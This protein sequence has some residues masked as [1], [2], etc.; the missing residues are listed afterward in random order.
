LSWSSVS[1]SIC[2]MLKFTFQHLPGQSIAGPF[3]GADGADALQ[4]A[5]TLVH[6]DVEGCGP[7]QPQ[8]AVRSSPFRVHSSGFS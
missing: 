5:A 8:L 6:N 2:L 7:S 3:Y 4:L 1:N